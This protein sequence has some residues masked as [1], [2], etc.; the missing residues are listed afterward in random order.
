PVAGETYKNSE[1]TRLLSSAAYLNRGFREEVLKFTVNNRHSALGACFGL[2]MAT[3]VRHCVR[4][5]RLLDRRAWWL[6]LPGLIGLFLGGAAV[7]NQSLTPQG[8][9][10]LLLV[11]AL[12]FAVCFYFD[13]RANSIVRHNFLR[14][15]FNPEAPVED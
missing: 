5:K 8:F 9:L 12:S 7:A 4:A 6:L 13:S 1:T 10:L 2:D 11:Y 14:S 3:V 15:N